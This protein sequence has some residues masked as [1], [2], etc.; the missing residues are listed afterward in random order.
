MPLKKRLVYIAF[1]FAVF[2]AF[3]SLPVLGSTSDCHPC[4]RDAYFSTLL[5]ADERWVCDICEIGE[6]VN[7][8]FIGFTTTETILS[9]KYPVPSVFGAKP[10]IPYLTFPWVV[11]DATTKSGTIVFGTIE[12]IRG[13]P[14]P[15]VME[16]LVPWETDM[17]DFWARSRLVGWQERQPTFGRRRSFN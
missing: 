17:E 1:T 13:L 10:V 9:G 4:I 11:W 3:D 5:Q 16:L 6:E 15:L 2:P 14:N 8:G 7:G 12:T